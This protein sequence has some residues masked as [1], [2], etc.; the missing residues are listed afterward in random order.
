MDLDLVKRV[1][2]KAAYNGGSILKK[3][4]GSL[5]GYK[6]KGDIDLVTI[7]DIESEQA[8]VKT[9]GETFPEHGILAEEGGGKKGDKGLWIIDPLD[10]TTNYAHNIGVFCISI[11]FMDKETL[12]AGI[13]LNPV[14]GELFTAEKGRGALLNGRPIFVSRSKNVSNSLLATG[15][16]YN[17]K[18]ILNPL[19][20]RLSNCLEASRGVRRLGAAA[21]DLCYLACGRFDGFWEQN[22]KPWDTAAGTIVAGEAGARVTDFSGRAFSIDKNEILVTNGHIH[23]EMISLLNI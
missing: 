21:L 17:V 3:H 16:P 22:L 19:M 14:T 12:L 6:K 13:V 4:F 23:D 2:V 18:T 7:A 9:I 8:I 1:G 10:G 20:T 15:F 11:A 5:D